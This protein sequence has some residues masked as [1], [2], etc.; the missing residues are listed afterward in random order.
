MK[1][2]ILLL[3][4]GLNGNLLRA[5]DDVVLPWN[6]FTLFLVVSIIILSILMIVYL[7]SC[8]NMPFKRFK[9]L[10]GIM[11]LGVFTVTYTNIEIPIWM[12]VPIGII[13]L[14]SYKR[15]F[16]ANFALFST[17][18]IHY[19]SRVLMTHVHMYATIV[20]LTMYGIGAIF[21]Y[22]VFHTRKQIS[23]KPSR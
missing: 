11:V 12:I 23:P 4:F 19:V 20:W 1:K 18:C 3:I 2:N 7:A 22:R 15:I 14:I 6:S 5:S 17:L 13:M 21:L 16:F 9:V 10:I 8:S